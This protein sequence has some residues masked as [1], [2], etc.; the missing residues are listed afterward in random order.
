MTVGERDG[1]GLRTISDS[2][3]E[4]TDVLRTMLRLLVLQQLSPCCFYGCSDV[5]YWFLCLA[6]FVDVADADGPLLELMLTVGPTENVTTQ[7]FVDR[8]VS[9][10]VIDDTDGDDDGDAPIERIHCF[11]DLTRW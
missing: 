3:T 4:E 9:G 10:T 1:P 7:D 6:G 5:A 11:L 8:T 2:V